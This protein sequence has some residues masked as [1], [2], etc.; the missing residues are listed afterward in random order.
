[1]TQAHDR[2]PNDMR[3]CRGMRSIGL[4]YVLAG[5]VFGLDQAT[6][7]AASTH[8]EMGRGIEVIP[9]VFSL[10]LAHNTGAAWGLF[11]G[12]GMALVAVAVVLMAVVAW[13]SLR[14]LHSF[15]TLTGL[16]LLFGG[17]LGNLVDRVR[18]GYVVDFLNFHIWPIFNIA[19]IAI[20]AGACCVVIGMLRT[21]HCCEAKE[22]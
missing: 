8:L 12:S 21:D 17:A 9:S 4:F 13:W 2:D 16:S 10:T 7:W 20:V 6:K 5:L 22:E 1:M 19:D 14:H 11:A 3:Q 15:W 18:L